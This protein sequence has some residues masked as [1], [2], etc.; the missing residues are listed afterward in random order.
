M[1]EKVSK[2]AENHEMYGSFVGYSTLNQ[3][4]KVVLP[5]ILR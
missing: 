5:V 2:G 1:K 4:S 3:E